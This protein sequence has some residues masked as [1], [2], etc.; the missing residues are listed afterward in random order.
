MGPIRHEIVYNVKGATVPFTVSGGLVQVDTTTPVVLGAPLRGGPWAAVHLAAWPR[1]HRRVL[2]TVEGAARIPGRY[3][4]D[5]VR[6]DETGRIAKGDTDK[7]A[8]ALGSG[9]EVLAVAEATVV[10][11]RNDQLESVRL[12]PPTGHALAEAAGN[13]VLL[14]LSHGRYAAYEHLRPGSIRV[15]PGERVRRGQ[16]IGALGSTGDSTGPHLHLHITDRPSLLGGEGVPYVFQR[17]RVLGQYADISHLGS[18]RWP[19]LLPCMAAER[20]NELQEA[21]AVVLFPN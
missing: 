13:Y 19:A 17:F 4:I 18:A 7:T 20:A 8:A 6:V 3:A 1:G 5:W 9:A 15:P 16:V 10:A 21:N 2:Y 12:S 11:T 14:Q